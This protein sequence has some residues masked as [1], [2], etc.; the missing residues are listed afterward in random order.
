MLL[1]IFSQFFSMLLWPDPRARWVARPPGPLGG[2]TPGPAGARARCGPT[3][4]PPR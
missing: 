2:P 4:G 1:D 3:P